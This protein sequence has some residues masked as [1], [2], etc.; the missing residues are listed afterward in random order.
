MFREAGI[1]LIAV[2][3]NKR[4]YFRHPQLFEFIMPASIRL[5]TDQRMNAWQ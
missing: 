3:L 2:K 4:A 5:I 1:V